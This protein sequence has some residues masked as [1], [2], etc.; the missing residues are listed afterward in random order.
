MCIIVG[1]FKQRR[2]VARVDSLQLLCSNSG[3]VPELGPWYDRPHGRKLGPLLPVLFWGLSAFSHGGLLRY[4]AQ[5]RRFLLLQLR[6]LW[7]FCRSLYAQHW[8]GNTVS[9]EF[10]NIAGQPCPYYYNWGVDAS[11]APFARLDL[12]TITHT[13]PDRFANSLQVCS[14]LLDQ[15]ET[16]LTWFASKWIE[17]NWIVC[18]FWMY[19][20]S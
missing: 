19:F 16:R 4:H 15:S 14:M 13:V 7:L 1:I 5:R 8:H 20:L 17:W 6:C 12:Q 11:G 2:H 9:E 10:A 18:K 3:T